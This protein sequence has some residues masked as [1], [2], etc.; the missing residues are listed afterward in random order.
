MTGNSLLSLKKFNFFTAN[1]LKILRNARLTLGY[2]RKKTKR[3][4]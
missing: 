4:A 3:G 2:S 1:E